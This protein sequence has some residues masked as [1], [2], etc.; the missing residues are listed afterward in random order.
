MVHFIALNACLP[1]LPLTDQIVNG[2]PLRVVVAVVDAEVA[3]H[4]LLPLLQ[5]DLRVAND[6]VK[7]VVGDRSLAL[8]DRKHPLLR[9]RHND[10]LLVSSHLGVEST[11]AVSPKKKT[12]LCP[13]DENDVGYLIDVFVEGSSVERVE[14]V[15]ERCSQD[16][17]LLYCLHL[18]LDEKLVFWVGGE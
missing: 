13:D 5:P 9:N 7:G 3:E 12:F 14:S 17:S 1:L 2:A 15:E 16:F 4:F 10:A 8:Q 11:L 18:S 6:Q